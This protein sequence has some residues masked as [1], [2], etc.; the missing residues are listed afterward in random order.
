MARSTSLRG[1]F[2]DSMPKRK[3]NQL[4]GGMVIS[5]T[6]QK[7]G[8]NTVFSLAG[9]S[10]THSLDALDRD[11]FK[12]ISGR[13]ET[14]TVAAA[15][16]FARVTGKLGVALIISDQGVPNAVS[17]VLT[18]YEACSPVLVI[19]A[20][21]S[22]A[23]IEPQSQVDHDAQALLRPISKW[24]RTVHAPERLREYVEVAARH[25]MSGRPG[26][27]VLQVPQEFL[28]AAVEVA[29]E[30][31]LP[32]TATPKPQANPHAVTAAAEL[33][34]GAKRPLVI[35]GGGAMFAN[36]GAA[37][38]A[39]SSEFGIPVMGNALGRGL[40]P[41]DDDLSWSWPLAQPAAREADVV[42]W[43][44]SRM[45][46]R[47]GYGM[48]PR[49][50][51]DA[52]MIQI[53]VLGEEIGRNR[54]IDVPIVA[55][56]AVATAAI[57]AELKRRKAK[58]KPA[59]KWIKDALKE[60]LTFIDSI[61]RG[62]KGP[63]HPYRLA[64]ELM[65]RMPAD[66]IYVGDGADIQNWMHAILRIRHERGFMDHYPL[67]SM[68]IGTPLALGAAAGA[69]EIAEEQGEKPRPVVHVTGD[70]A[71]G[72]YPSEYNGAVLAGLK[73]T[74]FISNDG[75]WGTEKHGQMKVI[76][77]P[78]NT[79]FGDVRYDLIGKAFG[80]HAEQVTKPK[81]VGPAI[82]RAF[83][84]DKPAVVDVVTDPMAGKLRKDDP[85][86][87]TIAFSDLPLS[88]KSQYTPDV[89]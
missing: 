63:I 69:R 30:L 23:S 52:R 48:A 20:R 18:A 74:T 46:Q 19:V 78:V 75:A 81:D 17:G 64:R 9:A 47:L 36:A 34:M 26:P 15:D 35:A 82:E 53:D 21:L 85:R 8:I 5:R 25:A 4:T 87:M 61:G 76:E 70:G 3:S 72:F 24:T 60:R 31:D 51:T 10:H 39:L 84:S 80:C 79:T 43:V 62:D 32:L 50:S 37:L 14:A 57:V 44:G 56:A 73:I 13:H 33:L 88:R 41:E 65:K 49:F 42:L 86:V 68:G 22:T 77:R 40:V 6:L 54:P 12:I 83:K 2:W 27:V 1:G 71:F 89:R 38:R 67:G 29:N 55:D 11:G 58:T 59:P 28:S 66:A 7:L 45:T 16:G